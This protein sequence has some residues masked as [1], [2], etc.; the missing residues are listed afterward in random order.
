MLS[1][2]VLSGVQEADGQLPA[3]AAVLLQ[4]VSENSSATNASGITAPVPQPPVPAHRV[5]HRE[6]LLHRGKPHFPSLSGPVSPTDK[7][8]QSR[9]ITSRSGCTQ[10]P[11]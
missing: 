9:W 10:Q 1:S 11:L 5:D 2:R 4:D 7:P 8:F 3:E 6:A